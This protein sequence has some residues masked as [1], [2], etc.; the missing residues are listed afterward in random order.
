MNILIDGVDKFIR[1][2][3]SEKQL[4]NHTATN[5]RRDLLKLVNFCEQQPTITDWD[6]IK[7]THIRQFVAAQHRRG[8]SG[9]SLHRLLSAIR[10]LYHFLAR[11]K[12]TTQNPAVGVSA[13]KTPRKLPVT[14]DADQLSNLLNDKVESFL[15]LRDKAMMELFYSSGLRLAE[16]ANANVGD[17]DFK[18]DTMTITGKGNKTRIVPIGSLAKVALTQWLSTR[19]LE[20]D[21]DALFINERGTRL[22]KRSIQSRVYLW[23]ARHGA[24]QPLHPHLLRHSFA[25]HLLESSSDL[26]SVQELLGHSNISTTQVY[27]HLDF[28]HLAKTYDK[29]HPRAHKK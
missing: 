15:D 13:P 18:T 14:L 24:D 29:A 9:K 28:Q 27:T 25:S 26:R 17:I 3:E 21:Q 10:S 4:S 6:S 11:E 22:S 2:L 19:K 1:Y 8:L 5:Y 23:G 7:Q 20:Q 16:L 12:I